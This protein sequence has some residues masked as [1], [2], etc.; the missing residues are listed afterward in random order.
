MGNIPKNSP[1]SPYLF[2]WGEKEICAIY[3]KRFSDVPT[4]TM[5]CKKQKK[6]SQM[7]NLCAT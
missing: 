2:P 3:R 7:H 4:K 5:F 6:Y 1:S